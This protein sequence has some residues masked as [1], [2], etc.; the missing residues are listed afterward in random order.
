[1]ADYSKIDFRVDLI[2][3]IP[4]HLSFLED[5]NIPAL[6][7]EN[8]LH[9]ALYRYEHLW[10]PL[11]AKHQ[12]KIL[13]APLDIAWVWHCH[14]LSPA[15]YCSDCVRLLNGQ[16]IDHTLE[17]N[18][19]E[20]SASLH[21]TKILW[22]NEYPDDPF[23]VDLNPSLVNPKYKNKKSSLSYDIIEAA[24]TYR[25]EFG[26]KDKLFL[27]SSLTRYKKFLQ[28]KIERPKMFIVPCY[29]IDLLWHTHQLH[30]LAYKMDTENMYGKIFNHDDS[31]TD[32]SE[33]SKL[34]TADLATR[35]AWKEVYG[36]NFAQYGAMYRGENPMGKLLNMTA[37]EISL[38]R[39]RSAQI[40]FEKVEIKTAPRI[41]GKPKLKISTAANTKKFT[42]LTTLKGSTTIWQDKNLIN[43]FFD[44]RHVNC[45]LFSLQ[46]FTGWACIGVN[47]LI[48]ETTINLLPVLEKAPFG[49]IM[50]QELSTTG[51]SN[52]KVDCKLSIGPVKKGSV[53]LQLK[54]GNFERAIMPENL[55]QIWGPIP[56]PRLSP[57]TD[58]WC[59]VASHKPSNWTPG[60]TLVPNTASNRRGVT[61]DYVPSETL[62]FV[63]AAGLL[64]STPSNFYISQTYG[65]DVCAGCGGGGGD[66]I[67]SDFSN[68]ECGSI[69]GGLVDSSGVV[70]AGGGDGGAGCGGCGGC[71]GG[72]GTCGGGGDGGGGG[73]CGGGGDGGGGAGCGGGGGGCGGG[74][75]GCGGGGCG[76]GCGG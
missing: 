17:R 15:A 34:Y 5:C 52:L 27:S 50:T 12:P 62:T 61:V 31:V 4:N 21:V 39:T 73:T 32:R 49:E 28:L 6:R 29:D 22:Q 8:I 46:E 20:K 67:V 30:P 41:A 9:Q 69:G 71:G 24:R 75:G 74:G 40:T 54:A 13:E 19:N 23:V 1:M 14:M 36:E 45:L 38:L 58:N 63:M 65:R 57:G 47:T 76:G 42:S 11:A 35:E 48:S 10:L 44:T 3:S 72:G 26:Y 56:L 51:D 66:I 33:G 25:K 70:D 16:I 59:E 64:M 60:Q 2:A 68:V 18:A 43:A 7:N 37:E 53:L 55:E